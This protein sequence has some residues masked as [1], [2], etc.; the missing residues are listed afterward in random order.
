M[1]YLLSFAIG[2]KL[3]CGFILKHVR[4][5]LKFLSSLIF[6]D[7]SYGAKVIIYLAVE[8]MWNNSRCDQGLLRTKL[9]QLKCRLGCLSFR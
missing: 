7:Y 6:N 5:K 3:S 8:K 1:A 9:D 2:I 4:R